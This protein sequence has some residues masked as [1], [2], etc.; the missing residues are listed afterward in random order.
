MAGRFV[1]PFY[2]WEISR[3]AYDRRLHHPDRLPLFG[4]W[5]GWQPDVWWWQD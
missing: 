3:I 1:I 5:P 2:S 4:D